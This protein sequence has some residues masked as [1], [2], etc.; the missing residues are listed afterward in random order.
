MTNGELQRL[1]ELI[2]LLRGE[3]GC[4]WDRAQKPA[5]I[6]SDLIGETYELQWAH[7]QGAREDTLE[8]LG[9]VVF[10]VVLAIHLIQEEHPAFTLER[11]V[12]LAD[13]KIR[14]RHP[15]VF[16]DAVARTKD[17]G[18]AHW[19]RIKEREKRARRETGDIFYDVPGSLPPI[20]KAEKIQKRAAAVGFDW[21]ETSGIIRK[22]RE[23]IEEIELALK[24]DAGPRVQEEI[25]D[26]FFSVINLSR[27]LAVDGEKAL[28]GASAKFVGRFLAM[29]GLAE[30]EAHRL[31]EMNLDEMD[32]YWDRVK[33]RG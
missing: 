2:S 3:D 8:E 7:A 16:G 29:K 20:R 27:F 13:E 17:E 31:E 30:T 18:L 23:E 11:I 4:P 14:R 22:I 10:L 6:L 1:F 33:K 5:G 9:D 26:L 28:S 32:R 12:S 15:H 24:E 19:N 25:G 21:E